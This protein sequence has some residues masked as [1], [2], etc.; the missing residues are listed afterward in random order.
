MDANGINVVVRVDGEYLGTV[1]IGQKSITF[2]MDGSSRLKNLAP[3]GAYSKLIMSIWKGAEELVWIRPLISSLTTEMP[4]ITFMS[5]QAVGSNSWVRKSNSWVRK[6]KG[7]DKLVILNLWV[8]SNSFLDIRTSENSSNKFSFK[9]LP[10]RIIWYE[11]GTM[12]KYVG[13]I[14]FAT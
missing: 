1:W 7:N 6:N 14:L 11:E 8:E 5:G 13:R 12:T 3:K 2:D 9:H 10:N 4:S